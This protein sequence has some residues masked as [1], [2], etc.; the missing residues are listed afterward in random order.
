MIKWPID[1]LSGAT[2]CNEVCMNVNEF[3]IKEPIVVKQ[4]GTVVDGKKRL[5]AARYLNYSVVPIR[6]LDEVKIPVDSRI[7]QPEDVKLYDFVKMGTCGTRLYLKVSEVDYLELQELV[8]GP[9]VYNQAVVDWQEFR[10]PESMVLSFED[11]IVK[12]SKMS[13]EGI[14][15]TVVSQYTKPANHFKLYD[16]VRLHGGNHPYLIYS[17]SAEEIFIRSLVSGIK[18]VFPIASSKL[19]TKQIIVETRIS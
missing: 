4:D 12:H 17:K 2:F 7:I 14:Y 10:K 19:Y 1:S 11:K 8:D 9:I 13:Y 5:A 16:I 3:G 18:K 15:T 6:L